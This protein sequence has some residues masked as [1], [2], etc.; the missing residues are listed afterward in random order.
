MALFSRHGYAVRLARNRTVVALVA[1]REI[2]IFAREFRTEK[3]H[4]GRYEQSIRCVIATENRGNYVE[5]K[6][7]WRTIEVNGFRADKRV[8]ANRS[9]SG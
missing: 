9:H 5:E 1:E 4:V 7:P 3:Y 6:N 8:D 2:R